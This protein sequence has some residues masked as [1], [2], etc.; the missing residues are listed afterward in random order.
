MSARV[1]VYGCLVS[2]SSKAATDYSMLHGVA[3]L[4]VRFQLVAVS[5]ADVHS[6]NN[7][8]GLELWWLTIGV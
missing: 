8:P 5:Q 6:L 7:S 3:L 1:N 2:P 4:C